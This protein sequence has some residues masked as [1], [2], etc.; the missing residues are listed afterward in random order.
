MLIK[1]V[2]LHL[3]EN[4][5]AVLSWGWTDKQLSIQTQSA[6]RSVAVKGTDL[7]TVIKSNYT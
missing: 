2:L 6:F 5:M 1:P 3:A 7:K 4:Y